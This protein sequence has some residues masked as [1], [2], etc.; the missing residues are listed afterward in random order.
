MLLSLAVSVLLS[1]A[2]S[3]SYQSPSASQ[4]KFTF[5]QSCDPSQSAKSF[6]DSPNNF[7]EQCR[8]EYSQCLDDGVDR[9]R[10]DCRMRRGS[11][12]DIV[13]CTQQCGIDAIADCIEDFFDCNHQEK[14][15]PLRVVRTGLSGDPSFVESLYNSKVL[16]Q[17]SPSSLNMNSVDYD[18]YASMCDPS[19]IHS[20]TDN[21]AIR[22]QTSRLQHSLNTNKGMYQQAFSKTSPHSMAMPDVDVKK[23]RK[24][25]PRG[26]VL[27]STNEN[28][29]TQQKKMQCGRGISLLDT[30]RSIKPQAD[31]ADPFAIH[32]ESTDQRFGTTFDTSMDFGPNMP[33]TSGSNAPGTY[34]TCPSSPPSILSSVS[35]FSPHHSSYLMSSLHFTPPLTHLHHADRDNDN[36][37]KNSQN[38]TDNPDLF[39][40]QPTLHGPPY[41]LGQKADEKASLN[42][43]TSFSSSIQNFS[44]KE[45]KQRSAAKTRARAATVHDSPYDTIHPGINSKLHHLSP[46]SHTRSR[47]SPKSEN[48]KET[49]P[50]QFLSRY[51][52]KLSFESSFNN[53]V[54]VNPFSMEIEEQKPAST[55]PHH[56]RARFNSESYTSSK[57]VLASF[58]L[59]EQTEDK[60]NLLTRHSKSFRTLSKEPPNDVR[61]RQETIDSLPQEYWE[62][63]SIHQNPDKEGDVV[64]DTGSDP[65]ASAEEVETPEWSPRDNKNTAI[66]GHDGFAPE[67]ENNFSTSLLSSTSLRVLGDLD[68]SREFGKTTQSIDPFDVFNL[69]P[70]SSQ[71][72]SPKQKDDKDWNTALG[73]AWKEEE[74]D[75]IFKEAKEK[76][77]IDSNLAFDQINF[78]DQRRLLSHAQTSVP[79]PNLSTTPFSLPS[80]LVLHT[81]NRTANSLTTTG[82]PSPLLQSEQE[83][84]RK[85]EEQHH[86]NGNSPMW[87][88]ESNTTRMWSG[89]STPR[90]STQLDAASSPPL[91]IDAQSE[92]IFFGMPAQT[93]ELPLTLHTTYGRSEVYSTDQCAQPST[94]TSSSVPSIIA[95]LSLPSSLQTTSLLNTNS[96]YSLFSPDQH[97]TTSLS[98]PSYLPQN[99]LP[100]SLHPSFPL[101]P[102]ASLPTSLI[103]S[104]P[105]SSR[106]SHLT[107]AQ[108][109]HSTH[110]S[111]TTSPSLIA[112]PPTSPALLLVPDG[113][114]DVTRL[115]RREPEQFRNEF[116]GRAQRTPQVSPLNSKNS[117]RHTSPKMLPNENSS[118]QYRPPQLVT[119]LPTSPLHTPKSSSPLT[120]FSPISIAPSQPLNNSHPVLVIHNTAKS[121]VFQPANPNL[122]LFV[123]STQAAQSGRE[124]TVTQTGV[125]SGKSTHAAIPANHPSRFNPLFTPSDINHDDPFLSLSRAF[126]RL[127]L[128]LLSQLGSRFFQISLDMINEKDKEREKEWRKKERE[129]REKG[130]VNPE[131]FPQ[132]MLITAVRLSLDE[133][134]P[135]LF[136]H[137]C[138]QFAN[139]AT[140]KLLVYGGEEE[141]LRVLR[142]LEEEENTNDGREV[143]EGLLGLCLNKFGMRFVQRIIN[144]VEKIPSCRALFVKLFSPLVPSLLIHHVGVLCLH[145]L[146]TVW[147]PCHTLFATTAILSNPHSIHTPDNKTAL[148]HQSIPSSLGQPFVMTF[149]IIQRVWMNAGEST[150]EAEDEERAVDV[151][152]GEKGRG[153]EDDAMRLDRPENTVRARI[154]E[155][156]LPNVLG[157]MVHPFAS[158][159]LLDVLLT[160]GV[161]RNTQVFTK[162]QN[163][164]F[165]SL[166]SSISNKHASTLFKAFISSATPSALSQLV[167]T[168][169][170][171][172]HSSSLAS[173]PDLCQFDSVFQVLSLLF[174]KLSSADKRNVATQLHPIQDDLVR[175]R[176]GRALW[177]EL[178]KY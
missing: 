173:I 13:N 152:R 154:V 81:R 53:Y 22:D 133:L 117:S 115:E 172:P 153:R 41:N 157:M 7:D 71:T 72:G 5:P 2:S 144:S 114:I 120:L 109:P 164:I 147:T 119:S 48:E 24:S 131:P 112:P 156:L 177:D 58:A 158:L 138:N 93:Q 43:H 178:V 125:G 6:G 55:P 108:S 102:I 50:S 31:M 42:Q 161:Y 9:C 38:E 79:T 116:V 175:S 29:N 21:K 88:R 59:D 96:N 76:E 97:T 1:S 91:S 134:L 49:T 37:H 124:Q 80:S 23:L 45:G 27:E 165:S 98:S 86:S 56:H 15:V 10:T 126:G 155:S 39:V 70:L 151:R 35:T 107:P 104:Q 149:Q 113:S 16:K 51:D 122:T 139:Y 66:K 129:A 11:N 118:V 14:N 64:S 143:D 145:S 74:G 94:T 89:T 83:T 63:G 20:K 148:N 40:S 78:S 77:I 18:R 101:S 103:S 146:L 174:R 34:Y 3:Y 12:E 169:F 92:K 8:R 32:F 140:Q 171:T 90:S 33:S 137:S 176:K 65:F 100:P 82:F 67:S 110:I 95:S 106:P 62:S 17:D 128:L 69:T 61:M 141:R 150:C 168:A 75:D 162:F 30:G 130:V 25:A 28:V 26:T 44:F 163:L 167:T 73:W 99:L 166:L 46:K 4:Y 52:T 84:E 111:L 132:L 121:P 135:N 57:L 142:R 159:L 60:K 123:P 68:R 160:R 170:L 36:T 19:Q 47:L 105:T 127:D 54:P 136:H 85:S 87:L